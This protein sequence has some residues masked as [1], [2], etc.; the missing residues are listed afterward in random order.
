MFLGVDTYDQMP[1]D[2][3]VM[4]MSVFLVY[5]VTMTYANTYQEG[6]SAAP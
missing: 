3:E 1:I 5:S 4:V 6:V 2:N